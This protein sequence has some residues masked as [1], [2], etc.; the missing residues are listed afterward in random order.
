MRPSR[1]LLGALAW[2]AACADHPPTEPAPG[3]APAADLGTLATAGTWVLHPPQTTYRAAVQQ[4]INADGSSSYPA[5]GRGVIP[6][7]F[8]LSAG[9]NPAI[10]RSVLSNTASDDDFS[11]LTFTP[12]GTLT[13]AELTALTAAYSF[14]QG[15]CG[16]GA[17][18]WS[19]R[20]DVGNDGN[21]AN[22]GSI[23]IYY[24]APPNF[25]DCIGAN[26]QTGANLISL[27]DA[28]FDTSQLPGGTFYDT[29]ANA[30][31]NYGGLRVLSASLVLDGG[32]F[33][34]DQVVSL[35]GAA[36][37][38]NAFVPAPASPLAPTCT[39]PPATIQVTKTAGAG[40]GPVNEPLS[41]QPADDDHLF[42]RVDCRYLYNLA[43][44]SL[45]GPGTYRV[46]AV[47]GGT[48]VP[49]PAI[50]QLR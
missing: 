27:T 28:R 32:W 26:D 18:R 11:F 33:N 42:R 22:D 21:P 38:G 50:F 29:H 25:T 44:S 30:A 36:V 46:E 15:N 20:L 41:V 7:K 19:V 5:T 23:F 8:A 9:T 37:N 47:I 6:V 17:L 16:G 4:P 49:D 31:T 39:L 2:L 12:S 1:L 3:R 43:T 13:F 45:S 34:G 35:G 10:L 40:S 14:T 24:G 48:P